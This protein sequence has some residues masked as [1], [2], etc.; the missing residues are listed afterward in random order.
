MH[1]NFPDELQ[2]TPFGDAEGHVRMHFGLHWQYSESHDVSRTLSII[3]TH[4]HATD[5]SNI[6]LS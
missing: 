6:H 2:C 1:R 5:V 3:K 4:T